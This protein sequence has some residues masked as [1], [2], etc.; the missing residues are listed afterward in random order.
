[1]LKERPGWRSED[2]QGAGWPPHHYRRRVRTQRDFNSTAQK[3][4][5]FNFFVLFKN[6]FIFG[7]NYTCVCVCVNHSCSIH[8]KSIKQPAGCCLSHTNT[9]STPTEKNLKTLSTRE[10]PLLA[11]GPS[12]TAN[13]ET[14]AYKGHLKASHP[15]SWKTFWFVFRENRE[16]KF[17]MTD[18]SPE[19]PLS[20]V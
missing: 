15:L 5:N 9:L 12:T 11:A 17:S 13:S 16:V 6:C 1:M 3:L 20:D 4:F 10:R 14:G 8:Q 19:P 2:L 7:C 18:C